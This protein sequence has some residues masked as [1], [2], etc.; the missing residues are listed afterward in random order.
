MSE[1]IGMVILNELRGFKKSMEERMDRLEVRMDKMA[2]R[3][4]LSLI[5]I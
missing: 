1:E 2:E 3:M 5:H 4:D